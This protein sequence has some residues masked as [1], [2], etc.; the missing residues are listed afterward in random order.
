MNF[1]ETFEILSRPTPPELNFRSWA[2]TEFEKFEKFNKSNEFNEF[3]LFL[4]VE[5][6][7]KRL[8]FSVFLSFFLF[9][10]SLSLFLGDTQPT[11]GR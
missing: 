2:D 8:F 6:M 3:N 5:K 1:L 9:S 10:F 7:G 11:K 4:S